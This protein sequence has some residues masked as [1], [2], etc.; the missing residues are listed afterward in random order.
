VQLV[1]QAGAIG[2]SGEVLVLDMGTPVRIYD[3]A[4]R[5]IA[6]SGRRIDIEL[7]GLRAGE[8]LHE[9]L[10]GAGEVDERPFHPL[11]SHAA[12]PPLDPDDVRGDEPAARHWMIAV[13]TATPAS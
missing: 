2:R 7:T 11:I 13:G 6:Q 12:V 10:F 4:R 8:K 3:V 5:L 1:I 9:D